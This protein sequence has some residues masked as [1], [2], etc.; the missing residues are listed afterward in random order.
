[1]Q[2][3]NLS[4]HMSACSV[5]Y[6]MWILWHNLCPV[7]ITVSAVLVSL[8]AV[9]CQPAGDPVSQMS[10]CFSSHGSAQKCLFC[11]S[12]CNRHRYYTALL[13]AL[14]DG[15]FAEPVTKID[16]R[17]LSVCVSACVHVNMC[18]LQTQASRIS[19]GNKR[20]PMYPPQIHSCGFL[21]RQSY[22]STSYSII[23]L[24]CCFIERF[25]YSI[26][27]IQMKSLQLSAAISSK[28]WTKTRV[29]TV[30]HNVSALS[31]LLI[32]IVQ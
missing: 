26:W 18:V 27:W 31:T 19:S 14:S 10:Q 22:S 20:P 16:S 13:M 30:M 17:L 1:M 28:M 5:L 11:H 25:T 2:W 7:S 23:Y 6:H 32:T 3:V 15:L 21:V 24:I 4:R 9:I 12:A 29:C 8:S